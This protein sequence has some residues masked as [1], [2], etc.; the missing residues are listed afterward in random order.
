MTKAARLLIGLALIGGLAGGAF[1]LLTLPDRLDATA[2]AA[3]GSGNAA[4]GER[5]FW[6]GGCTSCHAAG[7]AK[8]DDRLILAGGAPLET[9]FGTFRGPNISPHP[10]GLG[11]WTLAEFANAMQRGVGQ[12]GRH[13]YPAFPYT[14][15]QHMTAADIADLFAW[16][17]TLPPVAGKAPDN[18]LGFPYNIRRG[19]GLW[20][21]AFAGDTSPIIPLPS[22][23][24]EPVRRGQYLV[25]GPG[26]CGQCHT[27]RT[28]DGLGALDH[29][30]W[31]AGA[32]NPEGKGRIPNI[33]PAKLDWS[34]ADIASY[35][36]TGFTPD[37]DS[38]GGS[39]VEVQENMA[40]LPAEDRAAIAAYL[41]AIPAAE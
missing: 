8:G 14:S 27:P 1:L 41:K 34:A 16:L 11:N 18:E 19:I 38:V 3:E 20:K 28:L 30:K 39:M 13:L 36:E 6:A 23:A 9:P 40:K 29:G 15:Y 25:E 33:T 2:I 31:L 32:P 26:H 5:L 24:P 17:R 35:L 7:G 21:R 37:Y 4:R 12:D 22:D 10:D